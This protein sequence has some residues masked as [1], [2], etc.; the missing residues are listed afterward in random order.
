MAW[1]KKSSKS[2]QLQLTLFWCGRCHFH[3]VL[4]SKRKRVKWQTQQEKNFIVIKLCL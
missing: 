1:L 3:F 2:K 4:H